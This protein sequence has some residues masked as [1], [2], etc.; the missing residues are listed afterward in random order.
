MLYRCIGRY[1]EAPYMINEL[2]VRIHSFEELCYVLYENLY[3]LGDYIVDDDLIRYI[4]R[5]LGLPDLS[6]SLIRKKRQPVEFIAGILSYRHFYSE[7]RVEK[8]REVLSSLED[9]REYVRL[10]S[11]ADFMSENRRYKSAI[12]MYEHARELMDEEKEKDEEMYRQLA[13]KL[14]RLYALFYIFDKAA[15]CFREAGDVRK[16]TFCRRLSMSRVEYADSLLHDRPD[17]EIYEEMERL[18][19]KPE[20]IVKLEEVIAGGDR[21]AARKETDRLVSG[22]KSGYRGIS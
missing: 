3:S 12:L 17:G 8:A 16:S 2:S 21:N 5:E 15:V 9:I 6:E 19:A 1:A 22:L 14:G 10:I 20:E 11:R 7:D 13:G 4:E 18:T